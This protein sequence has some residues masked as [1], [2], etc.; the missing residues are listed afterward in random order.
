MRTS[1]ENPGPA[2]ADVRARWRGVIVYLA[3]AFGLA[4]IVQVA[5][6]LVARSDPG[7]LA[8]LRG[9]NVLVVALFLM[10]PPAIAAYVVRRTVE[11]GDFRDAGLSWPSWGY[12]ALAWFGPAILTV[13]STLLSLSIYPFDSNLST[14]R[15]A[16][17]APGQAAPFSP[18]QVLL[19]QVAQALTIAVVINSF[20]AFGEEFGWRGYLLPRLVELL[21]PWPGLLASGAIW[22]FWHAPL[23]LLVGYNYPRHPVL[24]VP[25]FV[26]ACML[27]GTLFGWL[28]LA[29]GSVF[30]STIAH[31]AFNAIAALPLVLLI[32]VEPAIGGVLYSPIGWLVLLAAIGILVATGAMRRAFVEF[33]R[34]G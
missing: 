26:I 4:W 14:L 24:G 9:G 23:I 15:R 5:L 21:G 8:L 17:Q 10:W 3:L 33:A 22:G 18:E 32:G 20:F 31:G 1:S 28:R 29:S 13:F 30:A 6:V 16:L 7:L 2:P 11:H 34:Y 27:I 12:V 19:V 25:L